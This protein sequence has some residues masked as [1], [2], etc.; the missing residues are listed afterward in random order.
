MTEDLEILSP[1]DCYERYPTRFGDADGEGRRRR[2][3]HE[4]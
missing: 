2:H 4:N 1:G 3:G